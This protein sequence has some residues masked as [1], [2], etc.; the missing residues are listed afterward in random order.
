MQA[1]NLLPRDDPN[2][3]TKTNVPVVIGVAGAVLT[4]VLVG[5]MYMSASGSVH[6]R[7]QELDSARAELAV[8]PPPVQQ[9]SAQAALAA[10]QKARVT[11][12]STALSTRI[13]WDRV[14]REVTLVLPED[15][16]LV[17]LA[18][19]SLPATTG[20]PSGLV[21][22]GYTYSVD[23][24]A[25]VLSRL[26]VVPDLSDVQL[27]SSS[28]LQIGTQNVVEFKVVANIRQPGGAPS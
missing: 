24:V 2:R 20:V 9:S 23:G 4:T 11:A 7:Q 8:V 27:T 5:M 15:V 21:I 17:S 3:R 1:V 22:D 13:A 25:R 16:W 26:Q 12:L 28:S 6:D 18:G 19:S 14:L 10:E